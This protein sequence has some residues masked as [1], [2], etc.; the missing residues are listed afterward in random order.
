MSGD[1]DEVWEE[2]AE[3]AVLS[4]KSAVGGELVE[5]VTPPPPVMTGNE[6][7][8]PAYWQAVISALS[9]E[10]RRLPGNFFRSASWV[11]PK[12][13]PTRFPGWFCSWKPTGF[14]WMRAPS[15]WL[16]P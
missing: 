9:P 3:P 8:L 12:G 2:P 15:A 16:T 5:T 10:K 4:A 14:S 1:E 13:R 6:K 11:W 7:Q